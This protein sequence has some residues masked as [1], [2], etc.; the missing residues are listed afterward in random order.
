MLNVQVGGNTVNPYALSPNQQFVAE[1]QQEGV[2]PCFLFG[3]APIKSPVTTV[4]Q[5]INYWN[6]SLSANV[7][8][9]PDFMPYTTNLCIT[10]S[11]PQ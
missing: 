5:N 10:P 3:P 11:A 6:N 7:K 8:Y 4:F 9:V 1:I 2:F